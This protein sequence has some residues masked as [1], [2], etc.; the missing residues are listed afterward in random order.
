MADELN[1][2]GNAQDQNQNDQT[3]GG[4]SSTQGQPQ[5]NI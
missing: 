4:N 5:E 1:A 2:E 3:G